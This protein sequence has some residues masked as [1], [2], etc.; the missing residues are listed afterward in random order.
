MSVSLVLML[1]MGAASLR[2]VVARRPADPGPDPMLP[3]PVGFVTE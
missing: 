1:A 3:L 2:M